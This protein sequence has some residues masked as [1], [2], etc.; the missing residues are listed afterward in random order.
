VTTTEDRPKLATRGTTN[1][2]VSGNNEDRRRRRE[3]LI[4]TYRADADLSSF[5]VQTGPWTPPARVQCP[6]GSGEPACRCYR[7]GKLMTAE[8]LTVDR[9]IPGCKGGTYRRDNIRPACGKCNSSTGS[10][11]AARPK[12]AKL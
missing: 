6:L 4:E 1:K 11:L 10:A 12:K 7:C 5:E 9:I 3:W 2:N 8:T